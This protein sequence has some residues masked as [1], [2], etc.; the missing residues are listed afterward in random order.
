MNDIRTICGLDEAGRGAL[1]GPLVAAAVTLTVPLHKIATLAK[2]P[3]RDSK[4]LSHPQR[5]RI[6]E[7]L[8]KMDILIETEVIS[9]KDINDFGIGWANKEAMR[10]LIGKTL[11]S[12]YIIDGNLKLG[13]F[14]DRDI[15]V[16]SIV[17]ADATIPAVILAGIVA[18]EYRDAVMEKLHQ[19]FP[20][21]GWKKN[22]GYGTASHI[23]SVE[24][25][26]QSCHHRSVFVTTALQNFRKKKRVYS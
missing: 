16:S 17:D 20:V 18:K 15:S 12:T 10:R 4:T 8:H 2:T 3:V 7:V 23:R 13:S 1:A 5:Q 21:Y 6:V 11:S 14:P 9:T 25:Y 22:K 19:Q 26:Q 24:E